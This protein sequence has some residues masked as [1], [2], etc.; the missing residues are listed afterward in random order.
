VTEADLR[1]APFSPT[2]VVAELPR[3]DESW[4]KPCAP[5]PFVTETRLSYAVPGRA[6]VR[7][8]IYDVSGRRVTVLADGVHDAGAYSLTWGEG[9]P[10]G[11]RPPAGVYFA[12]LESG[13]HVEARKIVL[14]H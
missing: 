14:T 2:S 9:N 8:A 5:N 4:L 7:L 10:R 13:A 3:T 1:T 11:P 6:W 12:R